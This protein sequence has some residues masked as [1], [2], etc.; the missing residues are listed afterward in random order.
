MGKKLQLAGQRF[1]RLLVIEEVGKNR[2]GKF[3][4]RCLCDCGKETIVI[5]SHLVNGLTRS[6]GCLNAESGGNYLREHGQRNILIDITGQRFG[7]LTVVSFSHQDPVSKLYYWN[8][9]CDCGNEIVLLGKSI[10][11]GNTKSCGCFKVSVQGDSTRTHGLSTKRVYKIWTNIKGRC[12]CKSNSSYYN[13]GERGISVC[14]EWE[15]F[16]VFYEWAQL[17]GY[18]D[19]LTIER[20]DVNGNYCPENCRWVT[21]KEQHNNT[22]RTVWVDYKG[23]QRTII[24]LAE[25]FNLPRKLVYNRVHYLKWSIK[26]ALETPK[27]EKRGRQ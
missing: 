6:C 9:K 17:T 14:S 11:S 3:L 22:R 26:E 15:N 13:Y 24:A 27:G 25:E 16:E 18:T 7:F 5:G 12:K 8:C 2:F 21:L 23:K 4:W 1:D 19:D 20:I 10:K